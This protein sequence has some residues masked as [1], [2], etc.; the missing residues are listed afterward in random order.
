MGNGK[1]PVNPQGLIRTVNKPQ[2]P[3]DGK[4]SN[5]PHRN[6]PSNQNHSSPKSSHPSSKDKDKKNPADCKSEPQTVTG[7]Q[8]GI[9]SAVSSSGVVFF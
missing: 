2:K 6:P 7:S 8:E 1:T 4:S 3:T 9:R 5:P